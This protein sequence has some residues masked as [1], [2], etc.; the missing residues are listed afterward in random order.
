MAFLS[1]SLLWKKKKCSYELSIT[2]LIELNVKSMFFNYVFSRY[3]TYRKL[4]AILQR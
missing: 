3:L 4:Y 1:K 2:S